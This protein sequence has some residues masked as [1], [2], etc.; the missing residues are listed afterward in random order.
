MTKCCRLALFQTIAAD[1]KPFLT[2]FQSND[3]LS[4]LLYEE[5]LTVMHRV[6]ARFVKKKILDSSSNIVR[7]DFTNTKN[8]IT[9]RKIDVGFSVKKALSSITDMKPIE[10]LQF[11]KESREALIAFCSSLCENSQLKYSLTKGISFLDPKIAVRPMLSAQRLST[12]LE[13]FVKRN[14]LT[15]SD[16]DRVKNS[17]EDV[18]KLPLHKE[19]WKM[20]LVDW[21]TF[22]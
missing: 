17:Y 8:L 10:D 13:I 5:L 22:G 6:M 11:K 16:A 21:I 14:R 4:P 12:A 7:T 19:I 15:G 9:A 3:P 20:C 18:C 1:V 2:K